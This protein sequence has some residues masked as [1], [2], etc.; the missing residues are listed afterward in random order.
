MRKLP[1]RSHCCTRQ[2][3]AL[4]SCSVALEA[5]RNRAPT[6]LAALSVEFTRVQIRSEIRWPILTNRDGCAAVA[7]IAATEEGSR[8]GIYYVTQLQKMISHMRDSD[9]PVRSPGKAFPAL[10]RIGCITGHPVRSYEVAG[11][12]T[13]SRSMQIF[14]A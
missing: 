14:P 9:S 3:N 7:N 5:A 6:S 13:I 1:V 10:D 2:S 11:L 12:M 8:V 4:D